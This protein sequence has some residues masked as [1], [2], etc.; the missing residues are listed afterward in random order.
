MGKDSN[1]LVRGSIIPIESNCPTTHIV[2]LMTS[3]A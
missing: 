1:C 2:P 3:Y